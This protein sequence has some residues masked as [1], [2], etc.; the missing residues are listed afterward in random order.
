MNPPV[1]TA[2]YLSL[3]VSWTG[4]ATRA[5][6]NHSADDSKPSVLQAAG[7]QYPRVDSQL[8]TA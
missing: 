4:A 3:L 8:V 6:S 2:V 7:Q 1:K 5:Q